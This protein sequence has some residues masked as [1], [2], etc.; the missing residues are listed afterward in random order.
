MLIATMGASRRPD[1]EWVLTPR[2]LR[3]LCAQPWEGN[4]AELS[5]LLD[6][7]ATRPLTGRIDLRDLPEHYRSSTRAAHLGGRERAERTAII[8]ALRAAGG[9]KLRAA[10]RLGISRTTLYRRMRALDIP[11]DAA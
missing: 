9:N 3:A 11:R 4:L 2:A 8:I 10:H 1:R 7:L 6:D 5:G